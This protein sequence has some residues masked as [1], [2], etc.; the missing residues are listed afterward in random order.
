MKK[1]F[2]LSLVALAST[3]LL[4]ACGEVKSGASNSLVTQWMRKLLKS[5]STLKKLV[6]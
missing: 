2:A 1:K 4:A 3:A 5:V 6:L